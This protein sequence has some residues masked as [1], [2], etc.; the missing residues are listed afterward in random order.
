MGDQGLF[1]NHE[2]CNVCGCSKEQYY[3]LKYRVEE[4]K[5]RITLMESEFL[6]NTLYTENELEETRDELRLL[7]QKY[8]ALEKSHQELHEV[9][10]DLEERILDVAA[11]YEKEKQALN[12]EVLTLSQKL[13]DTRFEIN[14]LEEKN[15]RYKKDCELAVQLLQCTPSGAYQQHK[16][17]TLPN[18][19]QYYVHQIMAETSGGNI[20]QGNNNNTSNANPTTSPKVTNPKQPLLNSGDQ[21]TSQ[22]GVLS[23]RIYDTV[24]A[25][26]VARAIQRRDDAEK[27]EME[28]LLQI[29]SRRRKPGSSTVVI[30]HD[31]GVQTL[32]PYLSDKKYDMLCVKCGVNMRD[33]TLEEEEL[34][35]VDPPEEKKPEPPPKEPEKPPL[36]NLLDLSDTTTVQK[37]EAKESL[38]LDFLDSPNIPP[39]E[40]PAVE[41]VQTPGQA[42]AELL[43]GGM[44]EEKK[45]EED[46]ASNTASSQGSATPGDS[47]VFEE[48]SPIATDPPLSPE[49][50]EASNGEDSSSQPEAEAVMNGKGE[51]NIDSEEEEG[52]A[53]VAPEENDKIDD[54]PA[55]IK[56]PAKVNRKPPPNKV[57]PQPARK[58]PPRVNGNQMNQR[59]Q[60]SRPLGNKPKNPMDG[61]QIK[62]GKPEAKVSPVTKTI[63]P[64]APKSS[65]KPKVTKSKMEE[66]IPKATQ[67]KVKG[68]TTCKQA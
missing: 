18:E 50:N 22:Y 51:K 66:P 36:V 49:T 40:P 6:Q 24:P 11:S 27:K 59:N 55:E 35:Q 2:S 29:T 4:S 10:Q 68:S 25:N 56:P 58:A 41:T 62:A 13:L 48:V 65:P 17:S 54:P 7:Q 67:V 57:G 26:V 61:N 5:Q 45:A 20:S 53:K 30:M 44:E 64:P 42:L 32:Y 34:V 23:S 38:L 15:Q 8:N 16:I 14:K 43:Y 60:P 31:K 28:K 12:R 39:P 3:A 46:N 63:E 21:V 19:L 1:V 37:P 33:V 47:G 9:N 52:S